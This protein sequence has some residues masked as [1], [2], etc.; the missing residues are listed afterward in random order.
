[1]TYYEKCIE[2]VI[3][4]LD[5]FKPEKDNPEQ[6]VETVFT[7]LQQVRSGELLGFLGDHISDVCHLHFTFQ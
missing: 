5:R 4:Q 7:S 1:M 6:Y 3:K 2:I